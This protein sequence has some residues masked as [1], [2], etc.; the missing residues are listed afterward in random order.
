MVEETQNTEIKSTNT[1][2]GNQ[3]ETQKVSTD[4]ESNVEPGKSESKPEKMLSQS[5]VDKIAYGN[6]MEGYE[7][8]KREAIAE[9]NQTKDISATVDSNEPEKIT[10]SKQELEQFVEDTATRKAQREHAQRVVDQFV[11]KMQLGMQKYS[12]FETVAGKLNIP[13]LPP[14]LIDLV[15]SMDNTAD[16][17]YEL[18]KNPS[19]FASVLNLC[20]YSPQAAHDELIRLSD[21]IKKN[22][23]AVKQTQAKPNEPL[24]QAKPSTAG[25][26]DGK[27]STVSELRKQPWLRG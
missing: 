22:Q 5:E 27:L 19:K 18:G 26:D 8:G 2:V 9:A 21:S 17:I 3:P 15:T 6:K 11:G 13:N 12:D 23:E 16:I 24:D 10:V 14:Q 20:N 25:T 4:K 1:D 7:R